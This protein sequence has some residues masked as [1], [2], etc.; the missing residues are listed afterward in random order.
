M[1]IVVALSDHTVTPGPAIEFAR[2]LGIEPFVFD[3]ACG[4]S[5]HA[6]PDDGMGKAILKFLA[7]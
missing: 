1:F 4:H 2:K 3:N 7:Q 6:C 5:L